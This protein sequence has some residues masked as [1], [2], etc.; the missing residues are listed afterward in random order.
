ML[1]SLRDVLG[2]IVAN[3]CNFGAFMVASKT[4]SGI[5]SFR[6]GKHRRRRKAKPIGAGWSTGLEPA[7][8]RTTIWGSTIEL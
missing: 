7:T 5:A 6:V 8:A 2:Q 1:S 3:A 4:V